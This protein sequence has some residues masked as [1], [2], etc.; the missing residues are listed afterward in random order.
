MVEV[1]TEENKKMYLE[2]LKV[3]EEKFFSK[4]ILTA[5]IFAI[6]YTVIIMMI[7]NPWYLIGIPFIMVF[8]YKIPYI[9]LISF[10]KR[11]EILNQYMFPNFL[12]Y[13]VALLDTQGN[14]YQTLKATTQYINDPLK[15]EVENLINKLEENNVDNRDAF[16]EFAEYIGSSEAHMIMN[17]IYDFT[18]EGIN[19]NDLIELESMISKLQENKTNEYIRYSASSMD[20]HGTPMLIYGML[21]VFIFSAL[22]LTGYASSLL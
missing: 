5:V 3:N 22:A 16:L 2:Y 20:K 15:S 21:Y 14:V 8:G 18:E 19:K 10:K 4:R 17:L 11:S 9:E 7:D 1:F 12:G 6:A 13:F